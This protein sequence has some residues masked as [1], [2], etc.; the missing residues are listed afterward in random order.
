MTTHK[1]KAMAQQPFEQE[2][3][4]SILAEIYEGMTVYDAQGDK[5]GTVKH[6][7]FG[8]VTA[9]EDE[10]GL[11]AATASPADRQAHSFLDD[12]A[13]VFAPAPMP[14]TLRHRLLRHGF[15]RI[16]STGL[17]A[18]DCYALPQQ[19]AS[20]FSDRMTLRVSREELIQR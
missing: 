9:E 2:E 11:G 19:I 4:R 14:E 20:V 17:F 12:L 6:V 7:H 13:R 16:D 5:V 15:I 3:D 18:S 1:G 8:A 10:R